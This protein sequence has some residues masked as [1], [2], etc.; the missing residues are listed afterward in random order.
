MRRGTG[1]VSELLDNER[2]RMEAQLWG[3]EEAAHKNDVKYQVLAFD[4]YL[5]AIVLTLV[6]VPWCRT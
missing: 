2:G 5:P 3:R 6:V 1:F 4:R